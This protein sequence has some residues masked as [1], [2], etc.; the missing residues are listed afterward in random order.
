MDYTAL[1][2]SKV[3]QASQEFIDYLI[4]LGRITSGEA[5]LT[6]SYQL[7]TAT[8]H[9]DIDIVIKAEVDLNTPAFMS[10]R[11][12]KIAELRQRYGMPFN[13]MLRRA[14]T[15]KESLM[16]RGKTYGVI[17]LKEELC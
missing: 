6:G 11:Q 2:M 9:S 1:D 3:K 17:S 14:S 7:G 10:E 16:A 4:S 5:F 13:I 12:N 8:E 15:F